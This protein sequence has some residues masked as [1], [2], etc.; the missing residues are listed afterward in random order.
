M[1]DWWV[2]R[3]DAARST[4]GPAQWLERASGHPPYAFQV[5]LAREGLPDVLRV[6]TGAGKTLAAVLPWL[7]R[8]LV[9]PDAR[10]RAG[11]PRWLVVILPQ[12]TLVEQT[13]AAIAGWLANLDVDVPLHLLMGGEDGDDREW[14]TYP[15]RERIFVGT[16]DMVLSRLLLRGFAESR[17]T[18]PMSFG[19]LHAGVQF[20]FDEVQLM[21]PGLP[22]SLQLQGL[23]EV[24][25]TAVA[26]RSMWMSATVDPAE[27]ATVDFCREL[28][29]V[30]LAEADRRG[31]LRT[32]LEATR[33]VR[34][35]DLGDTDARRYPRVLAER[36]VAA[37]RSG[38]RTLV[39]LNT[40]ERASAVFDAVSRL[41]D[42]AETVLLHSRYRPADRRV[43]TRRALAA[44]GPA[45]TIVVSTQ[46]LEAGVDVTSDTLVTETAPWS[47]VVQRAGRCNR[48]GAASDARL[49]W[50]SPPAGRDAPLPYAVAELDHTAAVLDALE[51]SAVTS[52]DLVAAATEVDRPLHP[53]LR[54]R[55]LLDLF[56][57][58][59]DLSGNDIDVSP[60]VRDSADRTVSVAWRP[61][62]SAGIEESES[63]AVGREELCPA[64][65]GE[66]GRLIHTGVTRA[67]VVD[68]VAGG[69]R[70]ARRDDVRPTAVIVL[71]A[72]RG[73]YLPERGFTPGSTAPV[74]P[75]ATPTVVPDA[76]DIDPHAV[77]C[78]RWVP[79][80][81]HLADVERATEE[82]LAALGE[83]PGLTAAQRAALPLAGRYH[84]L[85]KA[86]PSFLKAL[87]KANPA[88]P[89][90]DGDRWAKSP[91]NTRLTYEPPH[92]RHEL[93]S[94][95]VLLDTTLGLLDGVDEAD[96][97]TYLVL[98]HHGKVRL[99]VRAHPAEPQGVLLGVTDGE[100]T[101][102][103]DVPGAGIV[104]AR[105]LSLAATRFGAGSLTSRALRLRDRTDLG[106]FRLACCEALLRAADWR[107]SASYDGSTP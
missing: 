45:G 57:T 90:P 53:V 55:D 27:L 32:R 40:V 2:S 106:P 5:R 98:A 82:L 13:A 33:T 71:D 41:D 59:P 83:L 52:M 81:E 42:A 73:G 54:R 48:D 107:A 74:P 47:S 62:P 65:I 50:T 18:W 92:F 95:L 88:H 70:A 6:P 76:V 58:A 89:P 28:T 21:G 37:H 63:R 15:E 4:Q 16:Q 8:R 85:G 64:P 97:I 14:K 80:A 35:L 102:D 56:D 91:S 66:V 44:P 100:S 38:T 68:Q 31:P 11:T 96:L 105:P 34:R 72:A 24:L 23:R 75:V 104:P 10:V 94:A 87:E 101:L 7:Y 78:G 36:V 17:A 25:G 30:E 20:V 46:V 29:V 60:F 69:W 77:G 103:A 99:T 67:R 26:C 86:H 51:G 1:L 3:V 61:L 84:D 9:H 12:R 19:L 93:V 49:L 39:V 43:Q 22:T 79:L